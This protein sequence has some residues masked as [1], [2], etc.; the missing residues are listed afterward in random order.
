MDEANQ[1]TNWRHRA[2]REFTRYWLNV[3]YLAIVF[4]L[5][6]WYR[7][8]ILAHYDIKYLEYGVAIVEAMVLAKVILLADMLGLSRKI[9]RDRPLILPTLYQSV[10]FSLFVAVFA[11]V[12]GTVRGLWKGRGWGG[13]FEEIAGGGKYE[14]LARCLMLFVVFIPYFGFKELEI[15][16]GE[17]KLAKLFFR[18]KQAVGDGGGK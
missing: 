16:F 3:F 9:F 4:G 6:A 7:R 2:K 11:I 13:W 17:G 1:K 14:F 10:V 8:L 12:E 15:F 5:F 18:G